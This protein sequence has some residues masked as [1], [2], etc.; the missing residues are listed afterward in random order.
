MYT[1]EGEN[2]YTT[3]LIS[4]PLSALPKKYSSTAYHSRFL[5]SRQPFNMD[6]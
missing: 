1:E 6:M 4:F 5:C 3:T 2:I